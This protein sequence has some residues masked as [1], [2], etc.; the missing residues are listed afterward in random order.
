MKAL[1]TRWKAWRANQGGMD[2][3][4]GTAYQPEPC[5]GCQ[6][7]IAWINAGGH[8][9][10]CEV[11]NCRF[12]SAAAAEMAGRN[13]AT[14][15][16]GGTLSQRLAT[17]QHIAKPFGA[18]QVAY[19]R[20]VMKVPFALG[21]HLNEEPATLILNSVCG[22]TTELLFIKGLLSS[23]RVLIDQQSRPSR[24]VDVLPR[25]ILV[26]DA[27]AQLR[28]LITDHQRFIPHRVGS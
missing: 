9:T 17:A 2:L 27:Y 19:I 1:I 12:L 26:T 23:Q 10:T 16:Y 25:L 14:V 21:R 6:A 4:S 7:C 15:L 18:Y 28:D 24:Y 13:R 5:I 8:D 22:T 20:D 11:C 3:R